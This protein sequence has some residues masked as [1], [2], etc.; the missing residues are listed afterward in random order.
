MNEL[1][2]II[3]DY[4]E[5]VLSPGVPRRIR[6]QTMA[7]KA[8]VCIGVRRCGKSTFLFQRIHRLLESEVPRE[9]V[10]Y[11]NFF[12]DRLYGLRQS[13]LKTILDAYFSLHPEKKGRE[14]VHCFFDEIQSIP[15]WEAFVDRIL[16][17]ENCEVHITGSSSRMLSKEMATQ[18]RGRALSWEIFPFS[19]AEFLDATGTEL[20][21]PFSA[22][23]R[24]HATKA[25]EG[26]WERGAFPE[27]HAADR[28]LRIRTHQEYFQAMLL[29]DLIERHDAS[30]PKAVVD[31]AHRLV[32]DT[33]SMYTINRLAG[34]LKSLGH[35]VPK[36]TVAR[37]VELFEDAY[38]F[39]TVGIF[40][41]SLAR[42]HNNPKKIYC[43]DHGLVR[44]VS[45]NVLLN[46]GH[47]LENLVFTSLRRT[48]RKIAYYRTRRGGEVDFIYREEDGAI[49]LVQ[50]CDSMRDERTRAR[51]LHAL[52]EAMEELDVE[53]GIV[54][55]RD[56]DESVDLPG[57]TV[58]LKSIWRFLLELDGI[59]P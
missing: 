32:N 46:S 25:F 27:V 19:F 42:F 36:T 9:N 39:F 14:T 31:L 12:D 3:L 35:K 16:R 37:Y 13:G 18:L 5:L 43:I 15:G 41:A 54:V 40:D 4:R 56:E 2:E 11:L 1:R 30:H 29:R 55:T 51:E 53:R 45:S 33:A 38:V 7:G 22:R 47:L 58:E 48:H 44:S 50:V 59:T 57:G 34:Y 28:L 10:L 24:H 20:S 21:P 26:Y 23:D 52:E 8:T 6:L 17:M 49:R